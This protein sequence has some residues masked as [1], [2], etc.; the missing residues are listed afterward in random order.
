MTNMRG[1]TRAAMVLGLAGL[2]TAARALGGEG[3]ARDEPE[4]LTPKIELWGT[5][6]GIVAPGATPRIRIYPGPPQQKK[7][8]IQPR[9][10]D[11]LLRVHPSTIWI[12]PWKET[13]PEPWV[14]D[15]LLR[16]IAPLSDLVADEQLK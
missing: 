13:L 14:E 4:P 3:A 6:P 1:S 7:A 11:L 8:Y 15:L 12:N 2:L 5:P 9:F 10:R 16:R